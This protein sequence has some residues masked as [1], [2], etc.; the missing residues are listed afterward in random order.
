MHDYYQQT[1]GSSGSGTFVVNSSPRCQTC[2]HSVAGFCSRVEYYSTTTTSCPYLE[3]EAK[4]QKLIE[5]KVL[6]RM[7]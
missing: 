5:E 3:D 7:E 1:Y 2:K 4:M 6:E